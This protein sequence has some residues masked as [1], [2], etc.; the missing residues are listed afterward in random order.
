MQVSICENGKAEQQSG[1]YRGQTRLSKKE[2]PLLRKILGQTVFPVLRRRFLYGR[3]CHRKREEGMMGSNAK[4]AVVRRL[5]SCARSSVCCTASPAAATP[6]ISNA[7]P[8]GTLLHPERFSTCE[9]QYA[10]TA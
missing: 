8:P 3:C 10:Q 1:R 4:V 6:S 2:R 9:S 5:L 7:S